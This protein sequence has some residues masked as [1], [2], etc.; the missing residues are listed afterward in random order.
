M[1]SSKD[2]KYS[3]LIKAL[4]NSGLS[5]SEIAKRCGVR[6][7]TVGNYLTAKQ[8]PNGLARDRIHKMTMEEDACR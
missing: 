6:E 1:A 2:D 8:W 7:K 3:L 5:R 4:I